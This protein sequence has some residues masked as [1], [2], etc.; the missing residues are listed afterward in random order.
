MLQ[1]DY[2]QPQHKSGWNT[3]E[4]FLLTEHKHKKQTFCTHKHLNL[5]QTDI[6]SGIGIGI[7]LK[8]QSFSLKPWCGDSFWFEPCDKQRLHHGCWKISKWE[9]S[10]GLTL[11]NTS[12]LIF[13]IT[14]NRE[15]ACSFNVVIFSH[16]FRFDFRFMNKLSADGCSVAVKLFEYYQSKI[17]GKET[18]EHIFQTKSNSFNT[19]WNNTPFNTKTEVKRRRP[20]YQKNNKY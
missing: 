2:Y 11:M 10:I 6:I 18:I 19:S 8:K 7:W 1:P 16:P 13:S 3:A 9:L 17:R 14:F 4:P 5:N 15:I 20:Q 12:R